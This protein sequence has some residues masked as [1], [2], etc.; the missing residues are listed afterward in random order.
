MPVDLV[1]E[2]DNTPIE[3]EIGNVGVPGKSVSLL[4]E[5]LTSQ[6]DGSNVIFYTTNAFIIGKTFV[7][8]NGLKQ[9]LDVGYVEYPDEGKIVFSTAPSNSGFTDVVEIVYISN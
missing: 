2:V 5:D 6:V 1:V 8:V 7:F 4:F 3:I 9:M